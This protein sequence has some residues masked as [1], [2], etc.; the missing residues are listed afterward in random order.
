MLALPSTRALSA[1]P[2]WIKPPEQDSWLRAS[3]PKL[4][5][6]VAQN[7]VVLARPLFLPGNLVSGLKLCPTLQLCANFCLNQIDAVPGAQR[8]WKPPRATGCWSSSGALRDLEQAM[9]CCL[10]P[11]KAGSCLSTASIPGTR[12]FW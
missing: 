4:C 1:V 7:H 11:H 2:C 6:I 12:L 8:F 5:K 9:R 10:L 3:P